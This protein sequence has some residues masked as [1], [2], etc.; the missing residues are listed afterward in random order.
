LH[1]DAL[2][3]AAPGIAAFVNGLHSS[4]LVAAQ[5]RNFVN[6]YE[7]TDNFEAYWNLR[8]SRLKS[9]VRRKLP[10][11]VARHA[12]FRCY[13]DGVGEAIAA[14]EQVYRASWKPSEPH[15]RFIRTMVEKLGRDGFVRVG[16]MSV[17]GDPVAA[18]IWLL[19]GG[20]AT[21]FKLA[22]R[23]DIK[24]LSPGTLLT[25]WMISNLIRDD[26]LKEI[27]FGRGSDDY[28]RDWLSESRVRSGV[29]AGNWKTVA[30]LN[31]IA[32]EVLP[33]WASA[34]F[35]KTKIRFSPS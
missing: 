15:P 25:H 30:G 26:G 28:K 4:G 31:V 23:E 12:D 24:E 3:P 29:V 9:T 20:N 13:P 1:L 10:Q 8:P 27:D 33:T 2:D 35:R 21:I 6:F 22:H 19:C 16:V 11:A 17:R 34:F 5:Y 14:Y 18:Q 7:R 32:G